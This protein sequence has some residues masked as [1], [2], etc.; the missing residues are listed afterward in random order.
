M[1]ML[2]IENLLAILQVEHLLLPAAEEAESIWTNKF[3]FSKIN[4][5]EQVLS[6]FLFTFAFL[7]LSFYPVS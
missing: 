4:S 1:L 3:G 6:V 7:L 2:N 5:E